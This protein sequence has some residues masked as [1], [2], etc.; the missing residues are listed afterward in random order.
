MLYLD[1]LLWLDF[2]FVLY[3]IVINSIQRFHLISV[4]FCLDYELVTVGPLR[5]FEVHLFRQ[6]CC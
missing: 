6:S 5:I 1:L 4:R 2:K 3:T